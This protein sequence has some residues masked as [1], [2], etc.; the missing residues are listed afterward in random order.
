MPIILYTISFWILIDAFAN[1]KNFRYFVKLINVIVNI[2]KD[3]CFSK[4]KNYLQQSSDY[5]FL[6]NKPKSCLAVIS[7]ILISVIVWLISTVTDIK[8][9]DIKS[10]V[11]ISKSDEKTMIFCAFLKLCISE[12]LP[13]RTSCLYAILMSSIHF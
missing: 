10:H 9:T 11:L 8:R 7:H 1:S 3:A 13:H 2:I 5:Y 6:S 4:K 12:V